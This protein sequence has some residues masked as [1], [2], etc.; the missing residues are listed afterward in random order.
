MMI[1]SIIVKLFNESGLGLI[2]QPITSVSGG[3]MHRMY[4]VHAND[5]YYAVKHLNPGVMARESAADNFTERILWNQLLKRKGCQL[6]LHW[7]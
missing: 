1:E 4:K 2:D 7:F 5:K 3:F 6:F